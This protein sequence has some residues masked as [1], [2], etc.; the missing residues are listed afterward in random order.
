MRRK[1]LKSETSS[2]SENGG[3][4]NNLLLPDINPLETL[5]P[6]THSGPS[7]SMK[8]SLANLKEDK[9]KAFDDLILKR[10]KQ[11]LYANKIAVV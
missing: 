2:Q 9:K 7:R 8:L 5:R 1:L 3:N 11:D 4:D 10:T 6:R